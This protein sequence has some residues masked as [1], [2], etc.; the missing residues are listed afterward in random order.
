MPVDSDGRNVVVAGSLATLAWEKLDEGVRAKVATLGPAQFRLLELRSEAEHDD[1]CERGHL[2]YVLSGELELQFDDSVVR[3]EEGCGFRIP[4][5]Q[6][7]FSGTLLGDNQGDV[8]TI[9]FPG[10]NMTDVLSIS[11]LA[12][13]GSRLIMPENTDETGCQYHVKLIVTPGDTD[14]CTL[15]IRTHPSN[16]GLL[17][18]Q[19]IG[20]LITYFA[21]PQ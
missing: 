13:P 6:G 14:T 11:P 15:E 9:L 12:R 8:T 5:G 16:S 3:V 19:F 21:V 4:M 17:V 2:G 20:V 18:G 10:I 7:Y 1:W